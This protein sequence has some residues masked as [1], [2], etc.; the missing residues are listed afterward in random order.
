MPFVVRCGRLRVH[1]AYDLLQVYI[2]ET[3]KSSKFEYSKWSIENF[4]FEKSF[5]LN[6]SKK[7]G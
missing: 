2:I 5:L 4:S 7:K 1:S 3:S 6:H